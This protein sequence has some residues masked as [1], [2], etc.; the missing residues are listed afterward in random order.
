MQNG[1]HCKI[2]W[3]RG[4][5]QVVIHL[6]TEALIQEVTSKEQELRTGTHPMSEPLTQVVSLALRVA[7]AV[8]AGAA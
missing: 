5:V 7:T 8:R 2:H 1:V 6:V 4:Q 3:K